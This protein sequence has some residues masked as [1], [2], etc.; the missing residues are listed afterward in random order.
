[1]NT[2]TSFHK[3][4]KAL[5]PYQSEESPYIALDCEMVLCKNE[6]G[7]FFHELAR[8]SIVDYE[9]YVIIDQFVKPTYPIGIAFYF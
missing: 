4:P 5:H 9:N 6:D 7:E 2:S 3:H 1:M 8:V